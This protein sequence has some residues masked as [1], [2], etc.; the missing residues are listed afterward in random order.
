M[1]KLVPILLLLAGCAIKAQQSIP[2][3]NIT[4]N[5][6]SAGIINL[7]NNAN[8]NK[9]FIQ[10]ST[11]SNANA[12]QIMNII[13]SS[14]SNGTI[15]MTPGAVSG[16]ASVRINATFNGSPALI[17]RDSA[18][19]GTL[20]GLM[21]QNNS[22]TALLTIDSSTNAGPTYVAFNSKNHRF[23]ANY[24]SGTTAAAEFSNS[25]SSVGIA[26]EGILPLSASTYNLGDSSSR[27]NL[28]YGVTVNTTN[29]T[30]GSMAGTG[31]RCVQ[32]DNAG[33]LSV[34]GG[35]CSGGMSNPMTT[36][37]DM[38]YSSDNSGTP[39]RLGI[40]GLGGVNFLVQLGASTPTWQN[41]LVSSP[42]SYSAGIF[43]CSTCVTSVSGSG[44]L[45]STGGTTPTISCSTCMAN[46][47]T[48]T[49][50]M[51]YSSSGS[52]PAR[53]ANP[54]IGGTF[55]LVGASGSPP[56]WTSIIAS[57]PISYSSGIFSCSTCVTT[58]STSTMGGDYTISGN[59]YNRSFSGSGISCAG[60]PDGWTGWD[61]SGQY[62]IM[63]AGGARYRVNLTSY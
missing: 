53:L 33:S 6:G 58:G 7:R 32:V 14:T 19:G 35:G 52:T 46:P 55:F 18:N 8:V 15:L 36:T 44:L 3:V 34:F 26:S 61:T 57:S 39:A 1:K 54:S 50:D 16:S 37:G 21:L 30:V 38:I 60:V 20:E 23:S 51:I 11:I 12:G 28:I 27:W 25:G 2:G 42:L 45:S 40:S 49:Y 4:P 29:L 31:T 17:L 41:I 10:E 63:C 5:S 9:M 22:G 24:G 56:T 13:G 47:M 43:S 62:L 59:F 48:T